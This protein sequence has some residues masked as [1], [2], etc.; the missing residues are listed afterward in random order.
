MA[1]ANS[2]P[3][4][5]DS[6]ASSG[7]VAV[8]KNHSQQSNDLENN[9]GQSQAS[10]GSAPLSQD[11]R[12]SQSASNSISQNAEAKSLAL[13]ASPNVA[14]LNGGD[15]CGECGNGGVHQSSGASSR[16]FAGNWNSS[17][18]SNELDQGAEQSQQGG[19]GSC[20]G[21]AERSQ[22]IDQSQNASNSIEQNAT[23]RSVAVNASPNVAVLNSGP[24]DQSSSAIGGVRGE[25]EPGVAVEH[26]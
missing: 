6:N 10:G 5:Q 14:V 4:N 16:A 20:C 19:S 11:A 7:A 15:R 22:S 26:A 12:Q 3:V 1:I 23:A 17:D 24:V 18:Q 2:G 21:G 9:A 13:N 8:N 25:R